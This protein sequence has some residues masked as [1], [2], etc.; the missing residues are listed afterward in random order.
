MDPRRLSTGDV[1]AAGILNKPRPEVG[2]PEGREEE[3]VEYDESEERVAELL[4]AGKV[5]DCPEYYGIPV[6]WRGDGGLYR[7]ILL[8]YRNVTEE[9]D[10]DSAAGCAAWFRETAG[11]AMG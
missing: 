8:Q 10:F 9:R 2:I 7:G 1:L 5:V 3:S 4:E 6:A 11:A